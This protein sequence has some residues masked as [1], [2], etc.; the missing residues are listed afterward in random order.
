VTFTL[1]PAE[2]T[3][4]V[5]VPPIVPAALKDK[6]A[7]SAPLAIENEYPAPDPPDAA[8]DCEYDAPTSP[9]G[10]G[11]LVVIAG[12]ATTVSIRLCAAEATPRLSVA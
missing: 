6:P 11:E 7:G 2:G 12:A 3:A 5:G 8:S 4:V 10:S 9:A 1:K